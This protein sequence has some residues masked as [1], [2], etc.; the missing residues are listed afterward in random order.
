MYLSLSGRQKQRLQPKHKTQVQKG[1]LSGCLVSWGKVAVCLRLASVSQ[2]PG[3]KDKIVKGE[4]PFLL[5]R[6]EV[7]K[8][9]N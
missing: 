2:V 8:I 7:R 5:G 1:F 6:L 4:N 3:L 9:L